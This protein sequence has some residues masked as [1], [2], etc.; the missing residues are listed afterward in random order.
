MTF[1]EDWGFGADKEESF[2]MLQAFCEQG[3]NFIDTANTYTESTSEQFLGEFI[4][5]ER[6]YFVLSSKYSLMTKPGDLNA[7]GN[8]RKNML[9]AVD[10]SLKRLQTDYLDVYWLHVWDALTP[11]EEI[12]RSLEDL[13]RSGKV[14]YPGI[15]DT[16]AWIVSR[17][18]ML[19]ELRGWAHSIALQCLTVHLEPEQM[20]RLNQLS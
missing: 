5:E 3:G 15:S 6:D 20:D 4:A 7:G 18:N 16:P 10:A 13:V 19:T 2:A 17:A 11:L 14:L 1:G 8:Y 9:R 12:M